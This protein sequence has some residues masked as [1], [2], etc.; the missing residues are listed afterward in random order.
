MILYSAIALAV[1]LVVIIAIALR[2]KSQK[3]QDTKM[4]S[5]EVNAESETYNKTDKPQ[6][7]RATL[8][9]EDRD[10]AIRPENYQQRHL[11][12]EVGGLEAGKKGLETKEKEAKKINEKLIED[13]WDKRSEEVDKMGSTPQ[14]AGHDKESMVWR[15][16][17]IKLKIGNLLQKD[18][19]ENP[20]KSEIGNRFDSRQGQGGFS[21]MVK[22]R[23]DFTHENDQGGMSR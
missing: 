22:A 19:K 10:H 14:F 20:Q 6:A 8:S 15:L 23:R 18:D 5:N 21:Q 12:R 7:Y 17:K 4:T 1:V 3:T 16:K 11:D 13:A 9:L 2:K